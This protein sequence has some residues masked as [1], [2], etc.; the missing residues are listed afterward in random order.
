M[1]S[2]TRFRSSLIDLRP[3]IAFSEIDVDPSPPAQMF[4]EHLVR[5]S[6]AT[7]QFLADY[8][9]P[10]VDTTSVDYISAAESSWMPTLRDLRHGTQEVS[11]ATVSWAQ[12]RYNW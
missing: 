1:L 9:D 4:P 6:H 3:I 8:T 12:F 7:A 2:D 11:R 10:T 5:A